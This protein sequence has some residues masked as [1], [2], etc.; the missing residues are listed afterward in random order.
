MQNLTGA[1]M[2]ST[3]PG[4]RHQNQHKAVPDSCAVWRHIRGRCERR[5]KILFSNL[6]LS[7]ILRVGRYYQG[8]HIE[9][10]KYVIIIIK[11]N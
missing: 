4:A 3:V 6:H 8:Q 2:N 9:L 10:Y 1:C 11:D 7:G 5:I